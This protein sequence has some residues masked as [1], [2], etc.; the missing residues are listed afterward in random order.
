[1]A[2]AGVWQ[3]AFEHFFPMPDAEVTT[4][5]T[6]L[7]QVTSSNPNVRV[8]ATL[9]KNSSVRFT[10]QNRI[11]PI[12]RDCSI[13]FELEDPWMLP[14]DATVEWTVRNDSEEAEDENDLG[15]VGDTGLHATERSA[16][17]GTHYM[18]CVVKVAGQVVG[19]RRIPVLIEGTY[20]SRRQR[21]ARR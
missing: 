18:D 5:S 16:Y 9:R 21:R 19:H 4:D 1:L 10:G 2:A 3:E 13:E 12:P 15:H 20:L 17:T 11:G 14:R 8:S 7:T 6:A